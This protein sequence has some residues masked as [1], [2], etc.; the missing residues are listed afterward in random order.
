MKRIVIFGNSG[1]GKSTLAQRL[2]EQYKLAHLDLDTLAWQATQPPIRQ[3]IDT[4]FTQMNDFIQQH[5]CW[6]IEGCY[7]DLIEL[8]LPYC[9]E[10][11]FMNLPIEACI[12][13]AKARPWE[14]HKYASKAEQD[15]NLGMLI[16]W[17]AQYEAR[18]D[19]FSL[20]QHMA[21]FNE[22]RG[23][24]HMYVSNLNMESICGQFMQEAR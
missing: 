20:K 23:T 5:P 11:Y 12:E 8:A 2:S 4:S 15:D 22:F 6:V 24:K 13:N 3:P 14:P 1:S 19:T 9:N 10:I 7:G 17:I 21:I 18:Q 16:D